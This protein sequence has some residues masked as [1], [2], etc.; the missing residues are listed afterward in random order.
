MCEAGLENIPSIEDGV[1]WSLYKLKE[2]DAITY[3]LYQEKE[4]E[5]T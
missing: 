5:K 4:E 2:F 1:Y 3:N